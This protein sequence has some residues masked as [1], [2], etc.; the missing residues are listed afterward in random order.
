MRDRR[1]ANLHMIK[2]IKQNIEELKQMSLL[3]G[4]KYSQI[5]KDYRDLRN[6]NLEE[7]SDSELFNI[8]E[9]SNMK[10]DYYTHMIFMQSSRQPGV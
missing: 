7:C 10:I 1:P 2:K 3:Y 6:K 4:S 9:E 5:K 8:M